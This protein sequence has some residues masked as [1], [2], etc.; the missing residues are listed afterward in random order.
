MTHIRRRRLAASAIVAGLLCGSATALAAPAFAAP[1]AKRMTAVKS[2]VPVKGTVAIR[3]TVPIRSTAAIRSTGTSGQGRLLL[4]NSW[5][6]QITRSQEVAFA[7]SHW[8]WTAW[9]DSTPVTDGSDQPQYQCAE[10]VAR[11]MAA[12]G[13]IPGLT[14]D[15]PQSDYFDYT[16]PNGKVY[17]LLLISVLPQYNNIYDYLMDSGLGIDVGDDPADAQPGDFVVTYLG[18]N[19]TPSHMG[20]IATAPTATDEATVDAHNHARYHYGYHFYAPS[21]LVELAPNAALKVMAWAA[22]YN[23]NSL[24]TKPHATPVAP[25]GSHSLVGV[26]RLADP[27]GPQ[28]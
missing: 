15:A 12:A 5:L 13:L 14:P 2:K 18:P 26:G 4:W 9:D 16:A 1:S 24:L 17:D 6:D 25:R 20:L 10:F 28:V 8:N 23:F 7:E 27:A 21:H 3:S 11:S 22:K 19:N